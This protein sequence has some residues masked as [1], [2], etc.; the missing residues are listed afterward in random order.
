MVWPTLGSR[1][2]KEQ[3]RSL[4]C[5]LKLLLHV[6]ETSCMFE[7]LYTCYLLLQLTLAVFGWDSA[8]LATRPSA[9]RSTLLST[10]TPNTSLSVAVLRLQSLLNYMWSIIVLLLLWQV[11]GVAQ[12]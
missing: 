12:W 2:A 5:I 9:G 1:T 6:R 8:C 11:G 7:L 4:V 3:N 10:F